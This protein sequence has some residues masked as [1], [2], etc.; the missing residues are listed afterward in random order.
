MR[1]KIIGE[2]I[3]K[4]RKEKGYTQEELAKKIGKSHI[5]IR[6]YETGV[7]GPS[8]Y[9]MSIIAKVLEISICDILKGE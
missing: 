1:T 7:L 5:T 2:N 8:A 4:Y 9:S 6:K 3:K